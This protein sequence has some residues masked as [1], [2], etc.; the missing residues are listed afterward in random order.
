VTFNGISAGAA[1]FW[2]A[3]FIGVTVPSG[4]TTGNVVVTVG[5]LAS[6]GAPFTVTAQPNISSIS[7]TSGAAG[8]QVTV[9]GTGF[10]SAQGTGSVWLGSRYGT[11]MSWSDTQIVAT[12][13]SNATSGY[14]Q[15]Q[16]GGAWS[17]AMP[18]NV[19]T[20]TISSVTPSSGV[21][22]TLVTI[23]G[24][25]FGAAQGNGQV[26][27]GTANGAVQSWSDA[28]IVALVGAGSASGN[29]RVL[30]NGVLSN[31]VPFTVNSLQLTSISPT[32]GPVGTAVTFTGAGFGAS[33]GS[34][35]VQLGSAA[36]QVVSW[37]DTQIVATV[38]TGALTGIA[39][40]QQ[41]G[42]WSGSFAFTVTGPDG[43][44]MKLV[45]HLLNM[46][47]GDT[48]TI[49]ALNAAQQPVTGLTWTSSDPTV[50]SLST[51][52]P[53]VLTALAAGHVTITAGTASADVTVWAGELPV[54]TVLWSN[55]GDGSGVTKI[56]PAVPSPSGVADVFAFQNDG[57]VQAITSDGTTAWTADVSQAGTWWGTV[58]DFQGG[59]VLYNTYPGSSIG[60]SI[61]GL[62]G[63]TGQPK[64]T[65]T[66]QGGDLGFAGWVLSFTKLVVHP[67]GTILTF[68]GTHDGDGN[69]FSW[70]V[71]I[72]ST[73]GALKFSVPM[74]HAENSYGIIIAGDGYAY[75][76]YATRD[77]SNSGEGDNWSCSQFNHFRVLRIDTSG[78]YADIDVMDFPSRCTG[79]L[80][81]PFEGIGMIT[82]ADQGV[83]LT[84][85]TRDGSPDSG[86]SYMATITGTGVSV[87][88]QPVGTGIIDPV[89]QAQDG[90]YIG[91]VYTGPNAL[92]LVAFDASGNVRWMVPGNYWPQIATADGGVIATDQDTGAAVTFDQNGNA[93]GQLPS[94]GNGVPNWAG[95]LYAA[96]SSG[97]QLEAAWM[98]FG[99]GFA[100]MAGGNPSGNGT[101]VEMV[102]LSEGFPL[103]SIWS[104]LG[105]ALAGGPNPPC[106][107]GSNK[108]PLGGPANV[109]Y[110][111]FRGNELFFLKSPQASQ[112]QQYLAK[113]PYSFAQIVAAVQNQVAW[114]GL[115]SNLS[116]YDAGTWTTDQ[117]QWRTWKD[118]PKFPVCGQFWQGADWSGTVAWAQANP[119]S[120]NPQVHDVYF[121]TQAK[122]WKLLTPTTILH[123]ALHNLSGL[124]DKDL[125]YKLTGEDLKSEHNTHPIDEKLDQNGCGG[126]Q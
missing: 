125:Y 107:L 105:K 12:V 7:P 95:Q 65:Y 88:E 36:G 114:D 104:K 57:T 123:E 1:S 41:N 73:T 35:A 10:G 4:A 50:V 18:F 54:G 97:V 17:N 120:S 91:M 122:P 117:Q 31:P 61:V 106:A 124:S 111:A 86:A 82:N 30:Q 67:D 85:N 3:A 109:T 94:G 89:L 53:P 102:T 92:N 40:V 84:W 121:D 77:I 118:F 80:P 33:Q 38:A 74:P 6:N 68:L 78:S 76:P 49:Q 81:P 9:S 116:V 14:V 72:D 66:P 46:V 43:S 93:T 110:E 20:A 90:S 70:V 63:L 16:Q 83:L 22:G 96:G 23:S 24:S 112:C 62:D 58:P 51:D 126:G 19:S 103:F 119:T 29:A 8:V 48:H 101:S 87:T 44:S 56:V 11:V 75:A 13:A 71:G 32:S 115:Y 59:L 60:T 55:P 42:A 28:Q 34:G 39:T 15:V 64:F 5:G 99:A 79:D 27:L 2:N 37:S 108:V 113:L 100:S 69:G 52:D 26:W 98:S 47:V 45:P 25:G 21:P